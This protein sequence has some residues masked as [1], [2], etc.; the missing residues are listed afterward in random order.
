MIN[1]LKNT[2]LFPT[3]KHESNMALEEDLPLFCKQDDRDLAGISF[4]AHADLD[5]GHHFIIMPPVKT[6]RTFRKYTGFKR[7]LA[8]SFS[9]TRATLD[10]RGIKE[11]AAVRNAVFDLAAPTAIIDL[12]KVGPQEA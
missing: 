4:D 7:D 2:M 6:K 10:D 9:K 5:T 12:E 3:A 11:L 8:P 1:S